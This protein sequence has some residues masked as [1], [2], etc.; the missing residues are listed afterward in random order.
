MTVIVGIGMVGLTAAAALCLAR[1]LRADSF[2][3]RIVAL[4]MV[5]G[6]VVTGIAV[7]TAASGD[8]TLL[9]LLVVTALLG[10][11]GTVSVARFLER[12]G[13]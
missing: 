2:A 9:N 3:E 1:L 5:L 6:I 7:A 11:V 8:G 10:F 4:D 12:R 13:V